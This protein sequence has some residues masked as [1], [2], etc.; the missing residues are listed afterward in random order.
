MPLFTF[1]DDAHWN[2]EWECV[3][4]SV[5]IGEY[6]GTVRAPAE[7]FRRLI[8]GPA[9]PEKCLE[10]YHLQRTRIERAVEAKLRRRELASDGNVELATR[11]LQRLEFEGKR[12]QT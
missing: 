2:S 4:F 1:P 6:E 5:V 9:T 3:E 12:D 11:D 7:L 8:G 10:G